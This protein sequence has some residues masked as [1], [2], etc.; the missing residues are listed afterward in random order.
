MKS[1]FMW[2]DQLLSVFLGP[3]THLQCRVNKTVRPTGNA[4]W[5]GRTDS[6]R[7]T[8]AYAEYPESS[9][10]WNDAFWSSA[11]A[12]ECFFS[13]NPSCSPMEHRH[14]HN[15]E[16]SLGSERSWFMKHPWSILGGLG[17]HWGAQ[18]RCSYCSDIRPWPGILL[19][20]NIEA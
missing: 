9:L 19:A 17:F 7:P 1:L 13:H 2:T 11:S 6:H 12:L 16:G 18:Q 10:S 4:L 5:D 15:W 14:M 3:G 20:T 8:R